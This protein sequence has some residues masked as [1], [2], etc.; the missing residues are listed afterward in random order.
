[1]DLVDW[2]YRLSWGVLIL[3]GSVFA[4]I[5]AAGIFTMVGVDK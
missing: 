5:L 4:L 2:A 1:M 3:T